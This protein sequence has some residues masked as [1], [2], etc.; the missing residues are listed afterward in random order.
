MG[1]RE[2]GFRPHQLA[3]TQGLPTDASAGYALRSIGVVRFLLK[4]CAFF[5]V[6]GLLS[7]VLLS[8]N[9]VFG[10]GMWHHD[11]YPI[12]GQHDGVHG[13]V[14]GTFWHSIRQFATITIVAGVV[15]TVLWFFVGDDITAGSASRYGAWHAN[16]EPETATFDENEAWAEEPGDPD[17]K[18]HDETPKEIT[19]LDELERKY[20][21]RE[22][23]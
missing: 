22:V 18:E 13:Q 4:V 23:D 1:S 3:D 16:T 2:V 19:S 17:G 10:L 21:S 9:E 5:F 8:A 7:L 6:G 15:G 20:G 12:I 11:A 14:P